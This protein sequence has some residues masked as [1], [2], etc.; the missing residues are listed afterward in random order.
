MLDEFVGKEKGAEGRRRKRRHLSSLLLDQRGRRAWESCLLWC[1]FGGFRMW[2]QGW[3]QRAV[4]FRHYY[5]ST[6]Q[7]GKPS[8]AAQPKA[9]KQLWHQEMVNLW[10]SKVVSWSLS[11][12]PKFH[13]WNLVHLLR[14]AWRR[15]LG[16]FGVS[17]V[18][19]RLDA[20]ED[21]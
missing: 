6:W 4:L 1:V 19:P 2:G 3:T 5:A 13:I 18:F 15:S 21:K 7:H 9:E 11:W 10:K 17:P 16:V 14:F 12:T 8:Q 20:E